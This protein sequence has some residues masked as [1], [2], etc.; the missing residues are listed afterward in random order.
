MLTSPIDLTPAPPQGKGNLAWR[1][2]IERRAVRSVLLSAIILTAWAL[3]LWLLDWKSLWL[4]EANMLSVVAQGQAALWA[5]RSELYHPPLFY[6]LA[7]QGLPLG[8]GEYALRFPSVL[9]GTLSIPL[10]YGLMRAWFG[11][12][13]AV[14]A[15]LLTALSPLLIWYSQEFR[16]YALLAALGLLSTY[17]FTRLCLRPNVGWWAIVA[18]TALAG[19]YL[20]YFFFLLAPLQLLVWIAHY[21]VRRTRVRAALL[22]LLAWG[23]A[24]AGYWPWLQTRAFAA[25][26]A[27]PV[28]A[29]NYI[30]Q[31]ARQRLNL[32]AFLIDQTYLLVLL[33]VI[34]AIIGVAVM[35]A[36]LRTMHRRSLWP[37]LQTGNWYAY[38]SLIVFLFVILLW[39]LPRGYTA[40]RQ[41]LVLAPYVLLAFAWGWP[42]QRNRRWVLLVAATASLLATVYV[43][44]WTPKEQWREA[45]AYVGAQAAPGDIVLLSPRSM[46]IPYDYYDEHP[47]PRI[48]LESTSGFSNVPNALGA[49]KRFWMVTTPFDTD[50]RL[51]LEQWLAAN[52][53]LLDTRHL[54]R[55]DVRLYEYRPHRA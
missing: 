23:A 34:A 31:L 29:N 26:L 15:A 40:K 16:P 13:S 17:A 24:L 42:W 39:A 36:F 50:P 52:A 47:A 5:G 49:S 45:A 11:T 44:A 6:W 4:D 14:T 9:F 28:N 22:G 48:G 33:G 27:L 35:Y 8:Q 25:F 55:L 53:R 7:E 38:L 10:A 3:R 19:T 46:I 32:P 43:V 54:Y 21:A 12:P 2:D 41:L 37:R 20:H 30:A 1:W 18:L 51:G